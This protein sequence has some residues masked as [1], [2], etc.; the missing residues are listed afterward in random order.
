LNKGQQEI[1]QVMEPKLKQ[2]VETVAE[3]E[4]LD[5]VL[6]AQAVVYVK[7]DMDITEAV[8]KQLNSMK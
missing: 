3:R 8:T 4:N 1:L 7:S 5:M 2:A 6:N